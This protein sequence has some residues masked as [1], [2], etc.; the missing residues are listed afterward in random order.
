MKVALGVLAI[1]VA[2]ERAIAAIDEYRAEQDAKFLERYRVG[3]TGFLWW[4]KA[5]ERSMEERASIVSKSTWDAAAYPSTAYSA[6]YTKCLVLRGVAN[7]KATGTILDVEG[8]DLA[9][10]AQ[11]L[12]PYESERI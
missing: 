9:V 6:Q 12:E 7:H 11:H 3:H 1:K 2:A 5:F 10:I 8:E 4:R